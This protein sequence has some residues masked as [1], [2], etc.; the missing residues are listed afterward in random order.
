MEAVVLV[1]K[2]LNGYIAYYK[3][4]QKEVRAVSSYTAQLQAAV[5][6]QTNKSWDVTV[7]LCEVDGKQIIQ[8]TNF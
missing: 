1:D 5:L 2:P 8:P 6:F 4:K 7:V 3:G